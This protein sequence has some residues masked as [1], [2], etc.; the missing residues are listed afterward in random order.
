MTKT[1]YYVSTDTISW[2]LSSNS[3]FVIP[4]LMYLFLHKLGVIDTQDVVSICC[5]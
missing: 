4:E 1:M 5:D 3:P 2:H